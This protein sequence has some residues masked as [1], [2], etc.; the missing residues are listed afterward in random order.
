MSSWCLPIEMKKKAAVAKAGC[1][2]SVIVIFVIVV[3]VVVVVAELLVMMMMMIMM[4]MSRNAGN[5][6]TYKLEF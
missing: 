6:R 4:M 2:L 1:Q 3:V 5:R